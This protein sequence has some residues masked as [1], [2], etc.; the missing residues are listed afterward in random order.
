MDKKFKIYTKT[1][2]K[3]QTYTLGG[4]RVSKDNPRIEVYGEL[5]ELMSCIGIILSHIDELPNGKDKDRIVD[6]LRLIQNR[7]FDTGT[8]VIGGKIDELEEWTQDLE[9]EIDRMDD[10]LPLVKSFIL[11]GGSKLSSFTHIAR[12]VCRRAERRMVNLASRQEFDCNAIKYMNRLSDY[13]FT[14]A[15]YFNY[16]LDVEDV[17]RE[18]SIHVKKKIKIKPIKDNIT[19]NDEADQQT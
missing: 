5:D 14:L 2:D 13:L 3:G 15:R 1:G 19:D 10:K 4:V 7:L 18:G 17:K 6:S 8:L 11:P 9:E 16:L 12:C